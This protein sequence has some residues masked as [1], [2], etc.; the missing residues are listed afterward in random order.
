MEEQVCAVEYRKVDFEW[1]RSRDLDKASSENG[2]RWKIYWA[3]RDEDF[4]GGAEDADDVLVA[5]LM[6]SLTEKDLKKGM[7]RVLDSEE[8]EVLYTPLDSS[9]FESN[10]L[11]L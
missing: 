10:S 3:T 1:F 8:E 4:S 7:E 5:N 9:T 11:G 2:H 6:G